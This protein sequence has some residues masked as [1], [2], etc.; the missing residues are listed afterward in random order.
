M[1]FAGPTDAGP[2]MMPLLVSTVPVALVP[3][4]TWMSNRLLG[5]KVIV[6]A[7]AATSAAPPSSPMMPSLTTEGATSAMYELGTCDVIC[8]PACTTIC[9]PGTTTG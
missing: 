2:V 9:D 4:S 7:S 1:R 8:A 6:A 3:E 5:E